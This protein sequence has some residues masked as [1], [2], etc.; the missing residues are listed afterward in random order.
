M[1]VG[2]Y[3]TAILCLHLGWSAWFALPVALLATAVVSLVLGLLTIRLLGHFLPLGTIAWGL[4]LFYFFGASPMLGGYGGLSGIPPLSVGSIALSQPREFYPVIWIAVAIVVV[5]TLNLL[6]S[7]PGR[8]IRSLRTGKVAAESFGADTKRLK[9]FVFVYAGVLAGLSGWLYTLFLRAVSSSTFGLN[10]GIEYLL[11]AV[12]GG[13]GNIIGAVFGA[14]LVIVVRNYLQDLMPLLFGSSGN[15]HIIV[16]GIILIFLLVKSPGGIWPVIT[17]RLPK[18]GR[19]GPRPT[20]GELLADTSK[21]SVNGALL[22]VRALEKRFGGLVAVNKVDF[23]VEAGAIVG[24]IGPNGAGKS[25]TFNLITG[26]LPA[27]GGTIEF[28]GEMVGNLKS[29]QIASRGI[30]RT[31]QHVKRVNGMSVVENVALGAYLRTKAGPLRSMLRLDRAEER[32]VMNNA[33]VALQ[34]VGLDHLADNETG[35][36]ALG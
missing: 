31:F 21:P 35:S 11:M 6:N 26:I 7:R 29:R 5:L 22:K 28:M 8:V 13:A 14:A 18:M 20:N 19:S 4:A 36:L 33:R 17:Q 9:L 1:G 23:D 25:T 3:T 32:Q 16:F 12:I 2:A 24:L 30:A 10:A 15:F 27:S 34:R